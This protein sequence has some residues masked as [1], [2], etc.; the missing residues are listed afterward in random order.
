MACFTKR[1]IVSLISLT[2]GAVHGKIQFLTQFEFVC[3]RFHSLLS[4]IC[5]SV[6][7]ARQFKQ[8]EKSHLSTFCVVK[9]YYRLQGVC[10]LPQ[11][12]SCLLSDLQDTSLLPGKLTAQGG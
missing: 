8:F 5:L 11:T 3:V 4:R 10:C 2:Y 1:P 12:N 6:F 9:A 7:N